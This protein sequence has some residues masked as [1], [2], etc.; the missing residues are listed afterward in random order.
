MPELTLEL[1][2][3]AELIAAVNANTKALER[4]QQHRQKIMQA[5][6][7]LPL[8]APQAVTVNGVLG[9]DSP[10]NLKAKTGWYWDIKR[11]TLTGW[12]A[13]TVTVYLNGALSAP[14]EPIEFFATPGRQVYGKGHQLMHPDDR[15]IV[16][17][18]G[19]TGFVQLNGAVT[20]VEAWYLPQYLT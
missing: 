15:L 7:Q 19:I 2:L 12:S 18:T 9:I 5:I 16:I 13:G 14:G 8:I 6:R 3:G 20:A 10:D 11:L 1:D 4:E 17:G